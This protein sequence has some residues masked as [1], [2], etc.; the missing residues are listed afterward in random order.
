[1]QL[2]I[3]AAE[4]LIEPGDIVVADSGEGVVSIPRGMVKKVLEWLENRGDKEDRIMS[5]VKSG[6]SVQEAF[7]RYR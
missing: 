5:S 6:M 2:P 7:S 3:T 4:V 1:M